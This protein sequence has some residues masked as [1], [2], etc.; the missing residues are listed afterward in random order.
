MDA[1]ANSNPDTRA[2]FSAESA[3]VVDGL[4]KRYRDVVAVDGVSFT[5]ARG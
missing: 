3:I 2:V 4:T 1:V 5:V